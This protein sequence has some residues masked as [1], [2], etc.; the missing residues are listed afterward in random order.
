MVRKELPHALISKAKLTT[1]RVHFPS[2]QACQS[3]AR[4]REQE[5]C[6]WGLLHQAAATA[7]L[8]LLGKV[9]PGRPTALEVSPLPPD[10]SISYSDSAALFWSG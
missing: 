2:S 5:H 6:C 10:S 8:E 3:P 9:T 7:A 1:Q 4:G